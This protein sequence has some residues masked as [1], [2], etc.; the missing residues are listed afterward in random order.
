M[1]ARWQHGTLNELSQVTAMSRDFGIK[2][3]PKTWY[4]FTLSVIADAYDQWICVRQVDAD[5]R[6][7]NMEISRDI[8]NV[9]V[10]SRWSPIWGSLKADTTAIQF[11]LPFRCNRLHL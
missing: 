5:L 6:Y 9:P 3:P 2:W 1:V 7:I 11:N 10:H 4:L 8:D